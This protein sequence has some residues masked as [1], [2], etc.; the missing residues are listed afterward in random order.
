MHFA[1][2]PKLLSKLSLVMGL[3]CVSSSVFAAAA[4]AGATPSYFPASSTGAVSVNP[5]KLLNLPSYG[6]MFPTGIGNAISAPGIP[7]FDYTSLA[8]A[9]KQYAAQAVANAEELANMETAI[10]FMKQQ[11]ENLRGT[12]ENA[13]GNMI[14][15]TNKASED[16]SNLEALEQMVSAPSACKDMSVSLSMTQDV[17]CEMLETMSDMYNSRSSGSQAS[18]LM[19]IAKGL[20]SNYADANSDYNLRIKRI[21]QKYQADMKSS[22]PKGY[23]SAD[24]F[25]SEDVSTFDKEQVADLKDFLFI[26]IPPLEITSQDERAIKTGGKLVDEISSRREVDKGIAADAFVAGLMEKIP[27]QTGVSPLDAMQQFAL[28]KNNEEYTELV[29]KDASMTPTVMTREM[30]AMKAFKVH[31]SLKTYEH[32]LKVERVMARELAG[33]LEDN[34]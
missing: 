33:E 23:Y 5:S 10:E 21:I 34:Y 24:R 14:V 26:Q 9:L 15:R 16:V 6:G 13:F 4:A 31:Q 11:A 27:S 8:T 22:S 29:A 32:S 30:V 12:A 3:L 2:F 28:S 20:N 17:A 25:I 1:K 18:T 7:S 19:A